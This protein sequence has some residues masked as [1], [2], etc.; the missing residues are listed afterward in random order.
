MNKALSE[1]EDRR[2]AVEKRLLDLRASLTFKTGYLIREQPR[3]LFGL[4]KLPVG[5]WLLYKQGKKR[6]QRR[7]A[8]QGEGSASMAHQSKPVPSASVAKIAVDKD[9]FKTPQPLAIDQGMTGLDHLLLPTQGQSGQKKVACIMDDFTFNCYQPEC[10][11]QQL[12]PNGWQQE[13]ETFQPELL[14][15]ESAW[16][17]KDELW[18]RKV[19]HQSEEVKGIVRWCNEQQVPTVFWNKEDPVHFETFLSTAKL[20]DA[21][22]TTDIDCLHRYKAALGHERVY[23]LP[24]AC[25]PA[26]HNPIEVYQRKDAFSFAGAYYVRYPHRTK[27]LEGFVESLP[28]FRP[29]EI[30]DRNYD[31]DNS[32]YQFPDNYQPYIVGTLPFNEIDKAYKGY[33][34]AINLNSIKQSQS[35]FARR[36]FELLASNTLTISNFSRGIRLLFGDLVLATDSGEQVVERLQNL[37]QTPEDEDKLRLYGLRKVMQEHTYQDRMNYIL[38]KVEGTEPRSTLPEFAVFAPVDSEQALASVIAQVQQ[39]NSV[40]VALYP[41]VSGSLSQS[42]AQQQLREAELKGVALIVEDIAEHRLTDLVEDHQWCIAFL[43]EDYYGPNYL[44]DIALASRYSRAQVVGKAAYYD[45]QQGGLSLVDEKLSYRGVT[46]LPMRASAIHPDVAKSIQATGWLAQLAEGQYKFDA[47]LAID[48]FNYCQNGSDEALGTPDS[49]VKCRVDDLELMLGLSADELFSVAEQIQP[50][51]DDKQ[52]VETISPQRLQKL[53]GKGS[54]KVTLSVTD[55]GLQL[56]SKLADGKHEYLYSQKDL[57]LNGLQGVL[58]SDKTLSLHFDVEPGLNV[59]LVI[60]FLDASKQRI[61]HQILRANANHSVELPIETAYLRLGL[62]VY[63]GGYTVAKG[64][65]FAHKDLQPARLLGQSDTLLLTNHYPSYEDLY[66]NGFV[67]SR[68]KAYQEKGI[69]V[70]IFRLRKNQPVSWH[71]FQ[72]VDVTTGSQEALQRLLSSGQYLHVLVHFLDEELWQVLQTFI[73]NIHVTVW[74]H[75]AEVQPWW[76]REYNYDSEEALAVAKIESEQ[77][78][79]FWRKLLNSMPDNLRLVFVS[80]YFA[81]EVMEDVGIQLNQE[82]YEVIHNPID[83]DLFDYQVKDPEQ[84]KKILSIRPYASRKYA[85]DLSVEAILELSKEPWFDELDIRLIGD[86][87]LFDETLA[88]LKK[89]DNVVLERRFLKQTEIAQYHKEYGI[90]LCPT[91]MDAQGVSRDEA[92]SSGLIPVTNGV[93]AIPEFVDESCGILAPGDDGL[94]MAAGIKKLYLE[95]DYFTALSGSAAQRV[96]IQTEKNI[97]VEKEIAIFTGH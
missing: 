31:K 86:G 45:Y 49:Q 1:S 43:P 84:R 53:L 44:L 32:D 34:Y 27:D 62:R 69:N 97:I 33:R 87:S 83:T 18:G 95:P 93:T 68:V 23:L 41:A 2:R 90:F 35:M 75:G 77:R 22:F 16:R 39:Q 30:Y 96:R 92:M 7:L 59:S 20:F 13:L 37:A 81:D 89:F 56:E 24:F 73:E 66:R 71:E 40:V 61:S 91:R 5:L 72:S 42:Q 28:D 51:E 55:S 54:K 26:V 58:Q 21:I 65:L 11:L 85:N 63:A 36:V 94:E 78:L 17:G 25:Q 76:R 70:D 74:V 82:Q 19:G 57:P 6:S 67:H 10:R 38:S 52:E 29:L 3:S 50:L 9:N 46:A 88:P 8:R 60:L 48:R 47:Q 14:F 4:L 15:I 12:T 80:Q 64:I 79:G